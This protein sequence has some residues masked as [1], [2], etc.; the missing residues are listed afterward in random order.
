MDYELVRNASNR[1][2]LCCLKLK[3]CAHVN[4][5]SPLQ[6]TEAGD[7]CGWD[8]FSILYDHVLSY[9]QPLSDPITLSGPTLTNFQLSLA[10]VRLFHLSDLGHG[11][12]FFRRYL[13]RV[14]FMIYF[15]E[16][17]GKSFVWN[18]SATSRCN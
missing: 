5:G 14:G 15:R 7:F 13:F 9:F 11:P 10:N 1:Y 16:L 2:T 12:I 3:D 6:I 18:L 17:V 4:E 8:S